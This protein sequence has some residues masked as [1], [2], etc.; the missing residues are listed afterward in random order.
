MEIKDT[1]ST[2]VVP[3]DGAARPLQNSVPRP[4]V[5]SFPV[6]KERGPLLINDRRN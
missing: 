3:L 4:Q 1:K 2:D 6:L 5:V